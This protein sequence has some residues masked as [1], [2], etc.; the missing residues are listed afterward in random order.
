MPPA[1]ALPAAAA[2]SPATTGTTPFFGAADSRA[3]NKYANQ[4]ARWEALG[5]ITK[6]QLYYS[7]DYGCVFGLKATYGYALINAALM[8]LD[9]GMYTQGLVLT[10]GEKFTFV[11]Y[12]AGGK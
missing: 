1:L 9:R 2:C 4:G 6:L 7:P 10:P 12:K 5:D 8:G 3:A 11:D